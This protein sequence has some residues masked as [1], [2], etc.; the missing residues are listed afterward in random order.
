MSRVS[1]LL[2]SSAEVWREVRSPDG[3]GGWTDAWSPVGTVRARF[4]Q[5]SATERVVA[6]SNGVD[7]DTVVY[8]A[9]GADVLRGDHLRRG[10][11]EYEVR[12]V[13]EPS[14][15]NTYLRAD[16]RTRQSKDS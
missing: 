8:M 9:S 3:M 12:A 1:R 10:S 4:S 15:P 5:P 2:N 6:A 14:E 13:Y 16:C 7:L 11:T